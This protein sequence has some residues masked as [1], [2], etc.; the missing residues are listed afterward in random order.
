MLLKVLGGLDVLAAVILGVVAF[1]VALPSMLIWAAVI[2]LLAK[3]LPF[4]FMGDLA[5]FIDLGCAVLLMLSMW[6]TF[7][8]A[9]L[10]IMA[11]LLIAQKG[12]FS[13]FS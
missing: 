12:V 7:L 4:I 1:H 8:P 6:I 9:A 5:S 3:S 2:I 10:F 11:G 13:F